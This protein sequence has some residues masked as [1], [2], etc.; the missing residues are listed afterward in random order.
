MES[1]E[2]ISNQELKIRIQYIK[3]MQRQCI[4]L[5]MRDYE[6]QEFTTGEKSC[7]DRCLAK[8]LETADYVGKLY[9]QEQ[10]KK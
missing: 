7:I 6:K 2:K 8:Y 4:K 9:Q 3:N 10:M 1:L 5:C